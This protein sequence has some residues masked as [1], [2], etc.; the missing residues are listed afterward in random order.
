MQM[1]AFVD[2]KGAGE[3]AD[4][5]IMMQQLAFVF[6]GLDGA[7]QAIFGDGEKN[8]GVRL[9]GGLRSTHAAPTAC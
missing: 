5:K 8:L 1:P 4:D 3:V 6:P 9:Q 2:R 7:V